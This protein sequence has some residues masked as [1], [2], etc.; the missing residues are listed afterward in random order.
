[1]FL[2]VKQFAPDFLMLSSSSMLNTS[3]YW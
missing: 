1:M 3:Q 2:Y